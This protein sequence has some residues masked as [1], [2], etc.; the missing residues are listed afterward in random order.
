MIMRASFLSILLC[1]TALW[2]RAADERWLAYS[3]QITLQGTLLK[4]YHTEWIDLQGDTPQA[5]MTKWRQSREEL[6]SRAER[7]IHLRSPRDI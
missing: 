3:Q 7:T 5:A 2:G 6:T 1:A 4:H